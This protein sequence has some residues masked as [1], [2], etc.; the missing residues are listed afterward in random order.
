MTWLWAGA[1]AAAAAWAMIRWLPRVFTGDGSVG[2][3]GQTPDARPTHAGPGVDVTPTPAASHPTQADTNGGAWRLWGPVVAAVLGVGAGLVAHSAAEAA[4]LALMCGAAG[5]L[6]VVDLAEHRL[7]DSVVFPSLATW[8]AGATV[9]V[10]LGAGWGSLG[11]SALAA[12][13]FVVMLVLAVIAGGALGFG[14]VKLSA[15][16][17]AIL[18]W[19]GWTFLIVG[20]VTG[21]VLHGVVS[22]IVLA[23]TRNPKADVPMGP[24]LILGATA[25]F[26]LGA[27][28]AG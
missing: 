16:L 24:S 12:V 10:G 28:L 26:I 20:A 9:M 1:V 23:I 21:I 15:L 3:A 13:A 14:D 2:A 27:V 11:R 8:L 4:L 18:G 5:V 22:L 17:G 6:V 7:P 25:P 19:Y